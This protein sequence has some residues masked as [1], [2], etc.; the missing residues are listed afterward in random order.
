MESNH[1][2]TLR[3]IQR[4]AVTWIIDCL[5]VGRAQTQ[6]EN[7]DV[8]VPINATN[9]VSF[10]RVR[11]TYARFLTYS[12]RLVVFNILGKFNRNHINVFIIHAIIINIRGSQ[13]QRNFNLQVGLR[14]RRHFCYSVG[15]TIRIGVSRA[16]SLRRIQKEFLVTVGRSGT[17]TWSERWFTTWG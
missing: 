6:H 2:Q 7:T 8:G 14:Q 3:L 4:V 5:S 1:I 11:R 12:N 10:L 15:E 13:D 17:G 16:F 9:H